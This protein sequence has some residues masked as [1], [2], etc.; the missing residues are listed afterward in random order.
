MLHVF[1]PPPGLEWSRPR[2]VRLSA[3]G[4]GMA[5]GAIAM[6][7]AGPAAGY[8][9]F[10][11]SRRQTTERQQIIDHPALAAGIITKLTKD[12]KDSNSGA[13]HYAFDAEGQHVSGKMRIRRSWWRELTIG[14]PL[15]IRY[16]EG[17]PAINAPRISAISPSER[18]KR[19]KVSIDGL[20]WRIPAL[21]NALRLPLKP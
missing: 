13:V 17:A 15:T 16:A 20:R 11:E 3:A 5:I 4:R 14:E 2:A 1:T 8:A 21:S 12:S 10:Q 9:M 18:A 7:L 6:A 19:P